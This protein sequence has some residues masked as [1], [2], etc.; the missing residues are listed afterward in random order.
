MKRNL[1]LALAV[2]LGII[3]IGGAST[4]SVSHVAADGGPSKYMARGN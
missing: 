4:A 3:V 1:K 2:A